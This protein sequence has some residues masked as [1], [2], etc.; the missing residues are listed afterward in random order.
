MSLHFQPFLRAGQLKQ[1]RDMLQRNGIA[2]TKL[3]TRWPTVLLFVLSVRRRA[4]MDISVLSPR[5]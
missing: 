4:L 5:E 2:T 3:R 1:L